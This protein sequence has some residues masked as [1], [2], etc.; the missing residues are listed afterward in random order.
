MGNVAGYRAAFQ[1][2]VEYGRR[3]EKYERDLAHYLV[4]KKSGNAKQKFDTGDPPDPVARDL[5]AETLHKVLKGEILVHNHCY[6]ADEMSI[7]MDLGDEFGFSIRSFHHALEAYKI[8]DR[9]A[10]EKAAV[11]TWADW[12]GFKMESH[13][14]IPYNAALLEDAG[15]ITIIHSDSARDIQR[16]NQEA[17]KAAAYGR[18]L[19]IEIP[20]QTQLKWITEN[21]AW[22][23]GVDD[24]VGVLKPGYMADIVVWDQ[25]P[26]SIYAKTQRV[27]IDGYE[28]YNRDS[29]GNT[30]AQSDFEVGLV[31]SP[32]DAKDGTKKPGG[33]K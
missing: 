26:L 23:L 30:P 10:Q 18:D 7:M 2:A 27:Y 8:K 28:V 33:P 5:Q 29:T 17:A 31:P 19:G 22:A 3:V 13:D 14:G 24:K 11:S 32:T 1:R 25:M 20:L 21:A 4:K 12:W 9:L 15:A 16:L 6:R